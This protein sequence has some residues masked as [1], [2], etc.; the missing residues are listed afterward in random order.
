MPSLDSEMT[1][2]GFTERVLTDAEVAE[3]THSALAHYDLSGKRVLVVIPDGTRTAPIPQMFRL[4]H[5]ELADKVAALDFLIA[6]GTHRPMTPEQINKLVGVTEQERETAFADVRIFNHQWEKPETFVTL[7]TIT[8]DQVQ[9]ASNGMLCQ[10]V[11]VRINRLALEYDQIIV[12]GS[13]FPHEVVGFSGGNKYFFPGIGGPELINL[14]HWLGA[15]ITSYGII[16][17]PGITPVRALIHRASSLIPTPKLC[18]AMVVAPGSNRLAGLYVGSPEAAWAEASALSARIHVKYVPRPF[19]RVLSVMP[20]MYD[21]IWTAAKGMYKV[22]PVV[23]DGGEVIIYAPHISEFSYT[24]GRVLAEIGYHV[25]DYFVKQW[26]RFKDYP[27]GV[28]AHSTHL[29]GIGT[30]D[31]VAGEHPRIKVT[32]AT[33]ISAERCAAHALGYM[34]PALISATDWA[35]REDEGILLVPKAGEMLYR[36]CDSQ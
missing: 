23:A 18:F 28:L 5:G 26:D 12:C 2:S 24:H 4:C 25:R 29:R 19:K 32:L 30:Y 20:T 9:A 31:S 34:D 1:G 22:E 16:G 7:G 13:V 6:L 14:T 10:S 33:G 11:P 3:L 15:L 8:A 36:L 17:R 35:A 21:D 27:W